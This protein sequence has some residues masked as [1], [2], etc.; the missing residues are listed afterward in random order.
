MNK[1]RHLSA[2]IVGVV[3]ALAGCSSDGGSSSGSTPAAPV[4]VSGPVTIGAFNFTESQIMAELYAGALRAAGVESSIVQS[5]NREVLE[6]AL[7]AGDVQV[8]PEYLGTFTEFLNLAVN[9]SDA[10]AAA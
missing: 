1:G 5:T 4:A 2:L 3:L 10:P 7:E 8:V 6:P 9:G